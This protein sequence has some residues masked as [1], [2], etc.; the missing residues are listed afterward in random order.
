L[1]V[2]LEQR[3]SRVLELPAE[4]PLKN[5][6]KSAMQDV[7]LSG[8][9]GCNP[10]HASGACGLVE[11]QKGGNGEVAWVDIYG[12]ASADSADGSSSAA[13]LMLLVFLLQH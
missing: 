7:R 13:E 4:A 11:A 6:K 2:F 10:S 5:C 12:D 8:P 3:V 1:P 9:R